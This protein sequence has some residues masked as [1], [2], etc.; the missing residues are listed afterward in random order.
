MLMK[1][2]VPLKWDNFDGEDYYCMEYKKKKCMH[3][4]VLSI[5]FISFN[6]IV[7]SIFHYFLELQVLK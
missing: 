4:V 7:M 1:K 6:L 5:H 3:I 2:I